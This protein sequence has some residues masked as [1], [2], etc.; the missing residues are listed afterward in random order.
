MGTALTCFDGLY[1]EEPCILFCANTSAYAAH[2]H[3]YTKE[4]V[5]DQAGA[6]GYSTPFLVT[7]HAQVLLLVVYLILAWPLRIICLLGKPLCEETTAG[8]LSNEQPI[9]L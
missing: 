5:D 7:R 4:I 2:T 1:H 3:L 9:D 6:R 8:G